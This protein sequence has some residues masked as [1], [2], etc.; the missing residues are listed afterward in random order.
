MSKEIGCLAVLNCN[1]RF[2]IAGNCRIEDGFGINAH[3]DINFVPVITE[4]I[5]GN[6]IAGYCRKGNNTINSNKVVRSHLIDN[7]SINNTNPK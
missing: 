1:R 6:E 5:T 7:D 4:D 2:S 3:I